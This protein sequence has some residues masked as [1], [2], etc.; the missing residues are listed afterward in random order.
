MK[1]G[2]KHTEGGASYEALAEKLTGD[3]RVN[4]Y[5]TAA[6]EYRA[7]LRA[8]IKQRDRAKLQHDI[9]RCVA[10]WEEAEYNNERR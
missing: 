8:T 2:P 1:T 9:A 10:E 3:A 7:A 4:A 5:K 6:A